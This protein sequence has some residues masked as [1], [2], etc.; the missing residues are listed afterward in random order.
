MI[1]LNL[2]AKG[3]LRGLSILE[4]RLNNKGGL[5]DRLQER[6][7]S[8]FIN[9]LFQSEGDGNWAETERDN[10]ILRD[11]G[12]LL[13]SYTDTAHP[14][15]INIQGPL[16]FVY[17]SGVEYAVYHEFGTQHLVPRQVIELLEN[18]P[19]FRSAIDSETQAFVDEIVR[20][21]F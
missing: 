2:N 9:R 5:W 4:N 18:D 14:Q 15:N 7:L 19:D 16:S 21:V 1:T 20:E 12:N 8:V 10:P 13:R 6:V 3:T 17:G 11:T